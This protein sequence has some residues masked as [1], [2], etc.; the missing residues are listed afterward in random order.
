MPKQNMCMFICFI[1]RF[2]GRYNTTVGKISAKKCV[3]SWDAFLCKITKIVGIAHFSLK[4]YKTTRTI[5]PRNVFTFLGL[6]FSI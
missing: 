2:S 4:S 1:S 6:I 5:K 3:P